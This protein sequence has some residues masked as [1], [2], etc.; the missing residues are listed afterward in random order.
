MDKGEGEGPMAE[1]DFDPLRYPLGPFRPASHLNRTRRR[2]LVRDLAGFPADLRVRVWDL[3]PADM[4][5]RVRPGGWTVRQ[6]VHHLADAHLV[7]YLRAKLAVISDV[8]AVPPFAAGRWA[9]LRDAGEG[10]GVRASVTLLSSLHTRW[11][12]FLRALPDE[13]FL[14]EYLDPERGPVSLE[15]A[16]QYY[17]WHG[18]HHLAQ[19]IGVTRAPV[20]GET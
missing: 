7:G 15:F 18:R 16:L 10:S 3:P 8:P 11:V 5:T 1:P 20:L 12:R 14:R 9:G 4:D 17:T 19:I 6:V 13:A 2:A